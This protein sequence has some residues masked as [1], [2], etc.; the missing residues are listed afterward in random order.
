[1][2]LRDLTESTRTAGR[3]A[4]VPFL[5]AG[6]PDEATFLR[7][8]AAATDAG[9]RVVEVG[10]PFSDPMADGPVIQASSE[11]ALAQGMTLKRALDLIERASASAPAGYV[12][13]SYLNPILQMGI[14]TFAERAARAGVA[15][16]ILPDVP[17]EESGELRPVLARAGIALVDLV[18][19]TSGDER[20][21]AIARQTEGFLYLVSLTGVTG[22]RAGLAAGLAA[23]IARVR[24]SCDLPLYVGFGVST[25]EQAAEV[26]RSA[27]GVIIGSALIR[28]VQ[29]TTIQ[30][31]A[32]QNAA[33]QN[34]VGSDAAVAAVST[35]LADVMKAM[36]APTGSTS[37]RATG[38]ATGASS[39]R[40]QGQRE[41]EQRP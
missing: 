17:L 41:K 36:H 22:A 4:L 16:V 33:I 11:R 18:A 27:D 9:C 21:A 29:N 23:F 12:V 2:R 5:T 40:E 15:G 37:G 10:I 34:A 13:M 25:P 1:M 7:L 39:G 14:A 6:Y 8:L 19:P 24:R 30:N 26:A 35:F 32:V 20:V 28:I 3:K 38:G 31:A